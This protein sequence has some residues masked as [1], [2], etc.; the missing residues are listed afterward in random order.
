MGRKCWVVLVLLCAVCA[1][2]CGVR[3]TE[4][5]EL[6]SFSFAHKGMETADA[7]TY[8]LERRADGDWLTLSENDGADYQEGYCTGPQME[9]LETL[10]GEYGLLRWDGFNASNTL[11]MEGEAFGLELTLA[12]GTRVSAHGDCAYPTG[13]KEAVAA[14]KACFA[15]LQDTPYDARPRG[16]MD[17]FL[18]TRRDGD[19]S[20][21]L[22]REGETA[23]LE[24]RNGEETFTGEVKP[25]AFEILD[26]LTEELE[27]TQFDGM[28]GVS[29]EEETFRLWITW[30]SGEEIAAWSVQLPE[31]YGETCLALEEQLAALAAD[32]PL[33]PAGQ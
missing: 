17:G 30:D 5:P 10:A 8:T 21:S 14:I 27:L 29:G 31:E 32:C 19:F 23:W 18:Y 15:A 2:G 12:D 26:T 13:Y 3:P 25:S 33:I 6:T 7:Y 24:Y 1:A 4:A 9:A 22:T 20:F 28:T 16:S 11:A